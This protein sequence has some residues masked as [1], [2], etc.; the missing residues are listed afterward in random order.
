MEV[1]DLYSEQYSRGK[2]EEMSL[3]DFLLGCRDDPIMHADTAERMI[4][5]IGE[6][7]IIDT[8]ADQ[9]LGRVFLN[10][11]IKIYPA[12]KDF[13]GMEETIERVVGFFRH[14]A[15][16]LEERKRW[17]AANPRSPKSSRA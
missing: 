3:Q 12:F 17:G 16:G 1:F 2:Q 7:E 13:Y 6:P 10:R 5:A 11:T 4:A 14:A 15:Q 9:R 8:S